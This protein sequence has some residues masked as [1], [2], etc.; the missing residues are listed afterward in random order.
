MLKD[1]GRWRSCLFLLINFFLCPPL[2]SAQVGIGEVVELT[3]RKA[4]RWQSLPPPRD[5]ADLNWRERVDPRP[6]QRLR[7]PGQLVS[8]L[9]VRLDKGGKFVLG[10]EVEISVA[11]PTPDRVEL[12]LAKGEVRAV[13]AGAGTQIVI[14]TPAGQAML[15]GTEAIVSCGP[16]VT[17]SSDVCLFIG[18]SGTTQ[19]TSGGR[20]VPV[21][22]QF[23]TY[24]QGNNPPAPNPAQ[25]LSNDQ[26]HTRIDATTIVGTGATQDQLARTESTSPA[27]LPPPLTPGPQPPPVEP[28]GTR[29]IPDNPPNIFESLPLP[30]EPPPPSSF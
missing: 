4:Q 2:L 1:H 7:T 11:R 13:T 3:E 22:R 12:T 21:E 24:V 19:V 26:F 23:Y 20:T 17:P 9:G 28:P 5:W 30:P 14:L 29:S 6:R 27:I 15:T 16:P 8:R 10:E 25:P 18:V